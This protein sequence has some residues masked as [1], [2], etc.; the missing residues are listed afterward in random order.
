MIGKQE[1]SFFLL[2]P[3]KEFPHPFASQ[4]K[5]ECSKNIV[6]RTSLNCRIG[7]DERQNKIC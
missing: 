7:V 5:A 1:V 4:V 3:L 6:R 2:L